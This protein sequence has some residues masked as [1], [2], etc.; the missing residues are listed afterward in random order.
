MFNKIVDQ[1]IN[2]GTIDKGLSAQMRTTLVALVI[3]DTPTKQTY[4][5]SN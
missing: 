5:R 4:D 2:F 1:A 3:M